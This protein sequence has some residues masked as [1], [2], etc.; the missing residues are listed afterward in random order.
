MA[1]NMKALQQE[2]I[3]LFRDAAA[4]KETSRTPHLACAVTWKIFDAGY[5]LKD[6]LTDFTVMEKCVRHFLDTYKVDALIDIGIRNQF[7]VTEAFDEKSYYYYNDE[8]VGIHDHAHCTVDTLDEYIADPEK[9]IWT[10]ILPEKYGEAW[11]QKTKEVWKKTFKEYMNY[12]KFV[13]HMGSVT[14]KEYGLA[15]MAPNNPMK[16]AIQFGIEE[17]L[18]NLLGIRQLSLALRR[19]AD[20]LDRFIKVWDEQH[21]DPIIEKIRK[22]KGPE[23]SKYCFDASIMMLAQNFINPKQFERFY[24]PSLKRLL[25]A[26][27]EKNMSVRIFTEGTILPYAD[28]FKDYPKGLLTFHIEKDDPFGFREKL[29]NVAIMGGMTTEM[30]S[31]ATP[32]E[33]VEHTKKLVNELGGGFIFSENKMLSYRNDCRKE[34]MLAICEYLNSGR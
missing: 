15:S 32:E 27:A 28:Y 25:D 20:D 3:K 22:G 12:T 1:E 31:S 7:N 6:A 17:L 13:I 33:C 30:L 29:P 16:G 26:Y 18:A 34:N 10:R 8:S 11:G 19:N 2:R 4:F 21:I 23:D 14:S 5:E 9:Y 24:W